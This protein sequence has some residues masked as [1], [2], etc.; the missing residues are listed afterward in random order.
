MIRWLA[1]PCI[2]LA[3]SPA[4]PARAQD[5]GDQDA[6]PPEA[7]ETS[8]S[9]EAP[10]PT[11]TP[12]APETSEAP[13]VSEAP[14]PSQA[15]R[16]L[17]DY[18]GRGEEPMSAG[19]TA[20]WIPRVLLAPV[21]AV[22]EYGIH[23]PVGAVAT[24][25]EKEKVFAKVTEALTFG[26]SNQFFFVPILIVD[27]E[28]RLTVG[29]YFTV[30]NFVGQDAKLS[31]LG[32]YA[33]ER[34]WE[35]KVTE[36]LPLGGPD[37]PWG[38][39][40]K[41]DLLHEQRPDHPFYGIGDDT[42]SERVRY[43]RSETAARMRGT[44]HF[45]VLDVFE[46]QFEAGRNSFGGNECPGT[47]PSCKRILGDRAIVDRFDTTAIPGFEGYTLAAAG[48][49][50][51]LDSRD[52]RPAGG[53]GARLELTARVGTDLDGDQGFVFT[54]Y[55]AE[56]AL[57]LD[58]DGHNRVI[59]IAPRIDYAEGING[60]VPFTELAILGGNEA[61]RGFA[62]GRFRGESALVV[63]VQ[64]AWPIAVST[65]GLLFWEMGGVFG[66]Q[67]EGF[68]FDRLHGSFGLGARARFQR[69]SALDLLVA[70]GTNRFD[71]PT[72]E[73]EEFRFTFAATR[74]F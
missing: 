31:V 48:F 46:Y 1:P 42:R 10:G 6:P 50:V 20:L 16:P 40:L 60:D 66:P 9:P 36:R 26:E 58:L 13:E 18:D 45:G 49:G 57:F 59:G 4:L 74:G 65:D 38:D 17:P 70:W 30:A 39:E 72:L 21:Y 52:P 14:S 37:S 23:L 64:Y 32:T 53:S 3:L 11:E 62:K 34:G 19:E 47:D 54:R 5:T 63:P 22:T 24:W 25:M 33:G 8:E 27:T 67:F 68:R 73:V 35:L 41:I 12:E 2:A 61:M 56:L 69:D 71:A 44:Q 29:G 7:P 15:A 51:A 28:L 43:Y 55:G